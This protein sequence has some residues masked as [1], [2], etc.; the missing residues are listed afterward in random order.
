MKE[1]LSAAVERKAQL[2]EELAAV[3][4][5]LAQSKEKYR[6]HIYTHCIIYWN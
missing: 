3:R 4:D 6:Y 1:E 2:K 5:E